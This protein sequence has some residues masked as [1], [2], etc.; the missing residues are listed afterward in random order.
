[1][2]QNGVVE[3]LQEAG[4]S[5]EYVGKMEDVVDMRVERVIKGGEE[6]MSCYESNIGDGKLLVEWGFVTGEKGVLN[7]GYRE[8]LNGKTGRLFLEMRERGVVGLFRG[9][10]FIIA[11][12]EG[13]GMSLGIDGRISVGLVLG[14]YLGVKEDSE[15]DL[16]DVELLEKEFMDILRLLDTGFS[17]SQ[18]DHQGSVTRKVVQ[19]IIDLFDRRM[20]KLH[21]PEKTIAELYQIR[22]VSPIDRYKMVVDVS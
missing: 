17:T 3:R 2:V 18:S 9:N 13:S 11:G 19:A 6:V 1:V 7:W 4:L 12:D 5:E 20:A 16:G 10:Q 14:V 21:E 8:V 22:S 15:L